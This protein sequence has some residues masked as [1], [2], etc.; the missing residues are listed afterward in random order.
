MSLS[1]DKLESALHAAAH[2]HT[3]TAAALAHASMLQDSLS[4]ACE[5]MQ[6]AAGAG[7]RLSALAQQLQQQAAGAMT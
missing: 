6:A 7:A 3:S 2:A 4:D 5:V 1:Q